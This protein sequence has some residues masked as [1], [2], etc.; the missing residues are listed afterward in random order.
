[1]DAVG[2]DVVEDSLVVGDEE[3]GVIGGAEAV[4]A[5]ATERRAST[6]RPESGS[7]RMAS[8]G[9]RTAI[10]RTSLRFFSP[11]EKPS[12]TERRVI[13]GSTSTDLT[14]RR[15]RRSNL[16]G[17]SSSSPLLLLRALNPARRNWSRRTPGNSTGCWK[18]RKS[19]ARARSS[20]SISRRSWSSYKT[21]PWVA[22]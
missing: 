4:D 18:E 1:M 20:G 17:S 10:W 22:S 11:P 8:L 7:S 16:R 9:S 15:R 21:L 13:C 6:S 5:L 19:P 2:D 12:L 3:E 14:R